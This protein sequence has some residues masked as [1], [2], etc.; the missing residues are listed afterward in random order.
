MTKDNKHKLTQLLTLLNDLGSTRYEIA[1]QL[2]REFF[3]NQTRDNISPRFFAQRLKSL[4][5]RV[6]SVTDD[7][8][9]LNED[10]TNEYYNTLETISTKNMQYLDSILEMSEERRKVNNKIKNI[11]ENYVI[12]DKKKVIIR[13]DYVS[14]LQQVV[15]LM[16]DMVED[17]DLKEVVTKVAVLLKKPLSYALALQKWNEVIEDAEFQHAKLV[18]HQDDARDYED[19]KRK[20][21]RY[22]YQ[23]VDLKSLNTLVLSWFKLH[24]NV[25]PKS[26]KGRATF[27]ISAGNFVNDVDDRKFTGT[28]ALGLN[29]DKGIL[30]D[31]KRYRS[32]QQY[33]DNIV[34]N[35]P[36]S[37][38][39]VNTK[40]MDPDLNTFKAHIEGMI[41]DKSDNNTLDIHPENVSS[42]LRDKIQSAQAVQ[43]FGDV[44]DMLSDIDSVDL[45]SN[46]VGE[47]TQVIN[48]D[49]KMGSKSTKL[50]YEDFSQRVKVLMAQN[51]L[52]E[53]L[54][55]L[56]AS[57]KETFDSQESSRKKLYKTLE[58]LQE[59]D[60]DQ[61]EIDSQIKPYVPVMS[62]KKT[63]TTLNLAEELSFVS[64][65][66]NNA[67]DFDYQLLDSDLKKLIKAASL[68]EKVIIAQLDSNDGSPSQD[69]ILSL[70][71]A[72]SKRVT[73]QSFAINDCFGLIL[74]VGGNH[75]INAVVNINSTDKRILL[76]V[77]DSFGDTYNA[78]TAAQAIENALTKSI[79]DDSYGHALLK[80][81]YQGDESEARIYRLYNDYLGNNLFS[82]PMSVKKIENYRNY[83]CDFEITKYKRQK[84]T[85]SCGL[86]AFADLAQKLP[87]DPAN[88]FMQ[89]LHGINLGK[90]NDKKL[91][92]QLAESLHNGMDLINDQQSDKKS[93]KERMEEI[94]IRTF[95][96]EGE[97]KKVTASKLYEKQQALIDFLLSK[98]PNEYQ[99]KKLSEFFE[100][101]TSAEDITNSL[102]IIR[103]IMVQREAKLYPASRKDQHLALEKTVNDIHKGFRLESKFNIEGNPCMLTEKLMQE[104]LQSSLSRMTGNSNVWQHNMS[105]NDKKL[106]CRG[107]YLKSSIGV[108]YLDKKDISRQKH[109]SENYNNLYCS[110]KEINPK[111]RTDIVLFQTLVNQG[112]NA[113]GKMLAMKNSALEKLSKRE[114]KKLIIATNHSLN[115]SGIAKLNNFFANSWLAGRGVD[116][117]SNIVN[118]MKINLNYKKLRA[119]DIVRQSLDKYEEA[120]LKIN[121]SRRDMLSRAAYEL[122][123]VNQAGGMVHSSCKS[124]KDREGLLSIFADSLLIYRQEY[125]DGFPDLYNKED[126]RRFAKIFKSLFDSE[127]IM[128]VANLNAPA[129]YGI[130]SIK[131]I[132]PDFLYREVQS[133]ML[134]VYKKS[135]SL[136]K[137]FPKIISAQKDDVSIA[138]A[139]VF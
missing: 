123:A 6:E 59:Y 46:G 121:P 72:I 104:K 73:E 15:E 80:K 96:E 67:L 133:D 31:S 78:K 38:Q 48:Q 17:R 37:A 89:D 81:E 99:N 66:R 82:E 75:W 102:S 88:I 20:T 93:I 130:K 111:P 22:H 86:W 114:T 47:K 107:G 108:T 4:G 91:R 51:K 52:S 60:K 18:H 128:K 26:I 49:F 56:S 71:D 10:Y 29:K 118:Q 97:H 132:L 110:M 74:R 13:N 23:Q 115:L 129:S 127:H 3:L 94:H 14:K 35:I 69:N 2:E 11:K 32:A 45:D 68:E 36:M 42:K 16:Q 134:E 103:S 12:E 109:T 70:A 87:T 79:V 101:G 124:G 113:E 65:V 33:F 131:N 50:S 57:N 40:E 64:Q 5:K 122:I 92:M 41:A 137:K 28:V 100:K 83:Q 27:S 119:T 138:T 106:W 136:N 30:V 54:E 117:R 63:K 58:S 139:V 85:V 105:Y 90:I 77:T 76:K 120:M 95:F 62:A 61:Y 43:S 84:D 44:E 34:L 1:S 24:P 53:P 98:K 55:L 112:L 116:Y 126:Q 19:K 8:K 9:W 25:F 135:S 39:Y 125:K 21:K 7:S